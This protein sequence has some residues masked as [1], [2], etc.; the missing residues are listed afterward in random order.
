MSENEKK[1]ETAVDMLGPT[2]DYVHD[3]AESSPAPLQQ[4]A[5]VSSITLPPTTRRLPL[6]GNRIAV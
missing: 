2:A 3:T 4:A 1:I 5:A 6:R